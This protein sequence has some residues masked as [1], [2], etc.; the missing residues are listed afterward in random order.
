MRWLESYLRIAEMTEVVKNV[1]GQGSR[2]MY[3]MR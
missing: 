2:L 3:L 1:V